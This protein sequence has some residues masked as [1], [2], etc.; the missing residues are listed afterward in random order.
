V[1]LDEENNALVGKP[2][3]VPLFSRKG[4]ESNRPVSYRVRRGTD[5]HT[6][7]F[8]ILETHLHLL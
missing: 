5:L 1:A 3:S 8:V 7:T 6:V 4:F 2:I